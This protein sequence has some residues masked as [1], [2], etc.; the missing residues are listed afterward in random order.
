MRPDASKNLANQ[1]PPKQGRPGRSWQDPT[2]VGNAVKS[3]IGRVF[4][5]GKQRLR[6]FTVGVRFG[7]RSVGA[8][9]DIHGAGFV[10]L[11]G[12]NRFFDLLIGQAGEFFLGVVQRVDAKSTAFQMIHHFRRWRMFQV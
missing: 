8:F 9:D 7:R 3:G 6:K 4:L 10:F 11:Q 2:E 12:R 1:Y 5:V